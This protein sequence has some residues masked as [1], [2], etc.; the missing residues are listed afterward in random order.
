MLLGLERLYHAV[1]QVQLHLVYRG[2]GMRASVRV[3]VQVCVRECAR[4]SA[5]PDL[6]RGVELGRR[7]T[8]EEWVVRGEA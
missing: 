7:H 6:S 5:P 3:S 4:E 1:R 8:C 2:G